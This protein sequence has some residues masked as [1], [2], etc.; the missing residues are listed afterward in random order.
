MLVNIMLVTQYV[1][2]LAGG[3]EVGWP[4]WPMYQKQALCI[5]RYVKTIFSIIFIIYNKNAN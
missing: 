1:A 4:L 3:G 2:L 5:D